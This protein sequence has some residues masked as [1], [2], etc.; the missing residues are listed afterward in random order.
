MTGRPETQRYNCYLVDCDT[1]LAGQVAAR[2]AEVI[3]TC[4]LDM[5]YFDGA[6]SNLAL[7]REYRWRYVPQ[8]AIESA[9]MW[10]REVRVGGAVTGSL[11]V[12][13]S[14]NSMRNPRTF[15]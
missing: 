6:A 1:D 10:N 12:S 14:P 7:G 9:A 13:I 3:N 2:Y 4:K 5:I 11:F 8:I 15:T